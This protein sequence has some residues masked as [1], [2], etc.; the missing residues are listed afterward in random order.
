MSQEDM[1]A[2]ASGVGVYQGTSR[3][4]PPGEPNRSTQAARTSRGSAGLQIFFDQVWERG[5]EQTWQ[6]SKW[7]RRRSTNLL[8]PFASGSAVATPMQ[9]TATRRHVDFQI[10]PILCHGYP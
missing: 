9:I 5:R 3:P 7:K 1:E 4:R 8:F 6:S 10:G 2:W